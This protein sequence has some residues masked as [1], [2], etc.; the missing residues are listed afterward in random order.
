MNLP[1][2]IRFLGCSLPFFLI[3]DGSAQTDITNESV[4]TVAQQ[5]WIYSK[6]FPSVATRLN[7]AS[8]G[9][10]ASS[11]F[12][13]AVTNSELT[14]YVRTYGDLVLKIGGQDCLIFND[15]FAAQTIQNNPNF[16]QVNGIQYES[17]SF[18]FD[19]VVMLGTN[20]N[21]S[22]V[23]TVNASNRIFGSQGDDSITGQNFSDLLHGGLGNDSISGASGD[24]AL[25]GGENS[26]TLIGGAGNDQLNG[27][28][29]NDSLNG[30][31]GND[32]YQWNLGDG[33]DVISDDWGSTGQGAVNRLVFGTGILPADV[34][35]EVVPASPQH[36]R[37]VIRQNGIVGGSVTVNFWTFAFGSSQH[38]D[39]WRIEFNNGF[40][41]D[42][43][44]LPTMLGDLLNG[45]SLGDTLH[46]AAGNDTLN[47]LDG[48][49]TLNGDADN[50]TLNGGNGN[51]NLSGGTGS[52]TLNGNAGNDQLNGGAGSDALNGGA[53]NDIYQWNLG[54]GDDVISDDWGS[55]GQGAVNRLIFGPGI[56]PTDVTGEVVPS[57]AQH[58]RFIV[59][60]N[61][62]VSGSVTVNFWTTSWNGNPQHK[63][64]W[65]ISFGDGTEWNCGILGT[66]LADVLTG[67]AAADTLIGGA[68]NDTLH[69]LSGDDVLS[70][71]LHN[72]TLNGGAGNDQLNGGTGNDILNGAS[73]NDTYVWNLGDGDDVISDD[74]GSTGQGA[75][76]RLVFGPGILPTDV[77]GETVPASLE[78]IRFV[79]RQNGV[80]SGSVTVNFWTTVFNGGPQHKDTWRVEFNNG[81]IWDATTLPT[82]LGDLLNGSALGDTLH[83]GAGN[84]TL[85]GLDGDDTLNGDADNDTLNGG[86]GNDNLSGG[87]GSDTLNGNAGNDQL[88]GGA[89]NDAL[90]GGAGNDIYQ[91]NLGD[92]DD[93]INDDIGSTGQGAV[94]RLVF[95]PGILPTDVTSESVPSST[96]HIRF[97]VRQNGVVSGSVTINFWTF[98]FSS[99]QHKD[100]WRVEFNNG[101]KYYQALLPT[102]GSDTLIGTG[103]SDNFHG[104]AGNDTLNGNGGNDVL[105][106]GVGN[107]H[108]LGGL[109]S[110]EYRF[111]RGDGRDVLTEM[112]EANSTNTVVLGG[113][114]LPSKVGVFRFHDSLVLFD[115]L[116]DSTLEIRGW[117]PLNLAP[118]QKVVFSN[119]VEWSSLEITEMVPTTGDF[120]MDG[121]S[122]FAAYLRGISVGNLDMDGDGLL[123]NV[124]LL[125]GLNP[126]MMDSDEDGLSDLTDTD[127]GG[128]TGSGPLTI[129]IHSPSSAIITE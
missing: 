129:T 76:N 2:L 94:N 14:T 34:T 6:Q 98:I 71:G 119:G 79:V 28:T 89:G 3:Q 70:G 40:I 19:G 39:S 91:W 25:Y 106:G 60:Q 125:L 111:N 5:N 84:D 88:N 101:D 10:A 16:L 86:N 97:V 123:N 105:A 117:W 85:N 115:H 65:R 9:N 17:N 24:D 74:W 100:T 69:G 29:G 96:Q 110:D 11:N 57:S 127:F 128:G 116:S 95:G 8:Q 66:A 73:G 20:S 32:I 58:V 108:L 120:N 112:A 35:G 13:I 31:A 104:Y 83:G 52:D 78:H 47:G 45:S 109:G 80:V 87:T 92:G 41:W 124:E 18:E 23:G 107:D 64:T 63:D 67:G 38:K 75:I 118:I 121:I 72:D 37:F 102:S 44:T 42:A 93:V 7:E 114:I 22:L 27:G 4:I 12:L 30:G 77:T 33:D 48:D 59:R 26:D 103:E 55:T 49:D 61:G 51:D 43:T 21:D 90:N 56:L 46:G 15:W 1:Y 82:M 81:V 99:P 50:D 36:I 113:G 122:D 68:G 54:D 62:V 126:L 53:G